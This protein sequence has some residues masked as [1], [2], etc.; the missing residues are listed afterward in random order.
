MGSVVDCCRRSLGSAAIEPVGVRFWGV[1]FM[2]S[3][4]RGTTDMLGGP[5]RNDSFQHL[6]R[7]R[8]NE[9]KVRAGVVGAGSERCSSVTAIHS[10]GNIVVIFG[11]D[12]YSFVGQENVMP[13]H[14]IPCEG[15]TMCSGLCFCLGLA[16]Y[17][18]RNSGSAICCQTGFR[19]RRGGVLL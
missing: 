5:C 4:P 17:I 19:H 8:W 13:R 16:A 2:F 10:G 7:R 15:L 1:V 14:F 11:C 12:Y 9:R 18:G 6:T 3:Y